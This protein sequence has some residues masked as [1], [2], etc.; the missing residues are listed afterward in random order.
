MKRWIIATVAAIAM[1]VST[2]ALAK[3]LNLNEISQAVCRVKVGVGTL[4]SGTGTCIGETPDG[5]SYYVLTNAHVVGQQ[6]QGTVEFFKGGYKTKLL[7]ATVVWRAYQG[8]SDVDFAILTVRK[9]LFGDHQPRVIPLAPEGYRPQVNHYIA[10]VGCPGARWAQGWEGHIVTDRQSRVLFTP[11]PVGGQSGSGLTVLIKGQDGEWHTRVG[12]VLTWRIGENV[13]VQGGAIPIGTLY[14]VMSQQHTAYQVPVNYVEMSA[15]YAL[16]SDGRHYQI[17]YDSDGGRTVT[18]ANPNTRVISWTGCGRPDCPNCSGSLPSPYSWRR[19]APQPGLEP[20]PRP[21][22]VPPYTQP[23]NPYGGVNPPSIGAPWP[24]TETPKEEVEP[25]KEE[26]PLPVTPPVEVKP[27]IPIVPEVVLPPLS[28]ELDELGQKYNAF[29]AEK[30]AIQDKLD[31][32][33]GKILDQATIDQDVERA[34]LEAERDAAIAA[35]AKAEATAL[36]QAEADAKA[37]AEADAKQ[38]EVVDEAPI[39]FFARMRNGMNNFLGGI[40][41]GAGVGMFIFVW[42]KFLKKRVIKQVDSLQDYLELQIKKKWGPEMAKEARDVMEGVEDA[43]L[44]Y[45]DD[46]LEDIQAR[47]QVA[48]A[49]ATGKPA[50]RVINGSGVRKNINVQE[51]LEA[52]RQASNEVGDDTITTEIPKKVDEILNRVAKAKRNGG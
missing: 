30:Q 23:G 44:G 12:A 25:P 41:M 52:V 51:I 20:Q 22:E 15:K 21:G 29:A 50:E 26:L 18:F 8:G 32:L 17:R 45:A 11:A 13:S 38:E 33:E 46:F 5:Q 9:S 10:A 37:K 3:P 19:P 40:L 43:L 7:P 31:E 42:N 24:G 6:R 36:A 47:R 34:R 48:K 27:E 49:S 35:A 4:S 1:L 28:I 14:S 16:A 39:G 2:V